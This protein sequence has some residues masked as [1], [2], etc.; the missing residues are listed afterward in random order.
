MLVI[1]VFVM[2]NVGSKVL[3]L[4]SEFS[5]SGYSKLNA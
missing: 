3:M 4:E 1:F 2:Q 5:S